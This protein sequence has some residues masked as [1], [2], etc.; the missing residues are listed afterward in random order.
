VLINLS[1]EDE[2]LDKNIGR[3][4]SVVYN[5]QRVK[6]RAMNSE[7]GPTWVRSE[8]KYIVNISNAYYSLH[9]YHFTD[10]PV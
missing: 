6:S 7:K 2:G 4:N 8:W 10:K 3:E 9:S 1:L 5:K